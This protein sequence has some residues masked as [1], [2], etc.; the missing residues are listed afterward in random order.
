MNGIINFYKPKG[1]TSHGAVNFFRKLTGIKR[2]GHTGTLDPN[3]EGILPIC[4]GKATRVSEYLLS[5]DK[6][7]MGELILGQATD[8]QDKDGKVINTSSKTVSEED[9]R[10]SFSKFK[11]EILQ[12]PPMYSALKHKGKKLYDLAR[13]GKTVERTPRNINIYDLE[14]KE[15]TNNRKVS[16]Y[17]KCSRGTY[18][19]TLSHDIG[20]DLG[21]FAYMSKLTRV[22]VGPFSM[23]N[24]YRKDELEDL[25]K[26]EIKEFLL[27]ID[28]ALM[29]FEKINMPSE[30]YKNLKNGMKIKV[31]RNQY[32]LDE[33]YRVYSNNVFIGLGEIIEKDEIHL[34]KMNKVFV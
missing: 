19:R 1:I 6:A 28:Y 8:T 21:T 18:I 4:I 2:I 22:E 31:E 30:F 15:I 3:A 20:E 26:D 10:N 27:P 24:S 11:G 5:A 7:Y 12:I 34:L 14:I 13:E 32:N 33:L 23:K 9:I 29:Q 17:V 25:G 16:F